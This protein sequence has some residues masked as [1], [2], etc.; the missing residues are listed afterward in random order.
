MRGWRFA[1]L[2]GLSM[3]V[4]LA[5]AGGAWALFGP[6]EL[7]NEKLVIKFHNEVV[8]GGYKVV[9]TATLKKWLDQK[10][11]MLIVDTMP[12]DASYKKHHIPTAKQFEFPVQ[13]VTRLDAKRQEA[14]RKFLGPDKDRLI[15]VYCGFPKCG[16][17]HNGAMWAVKLGYR[18]V[19]R[20]PGGIKAWLEADYPVEE[21]D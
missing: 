18:N 10:R 16:R 12:Y 19:Y 20:Y 17:S 1:A 13:E 14:Y 9:D 8:R 4:L 7:D 6:K 5:Y 15:V 21:A 11:P 2:V 3:V